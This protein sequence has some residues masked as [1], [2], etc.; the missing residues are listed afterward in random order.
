MLEI[1]KENLLKS[2]DLFANGESQAAS[3]NE[4]N[5]NESF[6][7]LVGRFKSLNLYFL[8]FL[9]KFFLN[10]IG[11]NENLTLNPIYIPRSLVFKFTFENISKL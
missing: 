6:Q 2:L 9:N 10:N 5:K 1:K 11:F 3:S 4:A 8:M 7:D